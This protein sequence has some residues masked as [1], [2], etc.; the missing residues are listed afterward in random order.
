MKVCLN[1]DVKARWAGKTIHLDYEQNFYSDLFISVLIVTILSGA[2]LCIEN[3]EKRL[4]KALFMKGS[5]EVL[6]SWFLSQVCTLS[7]CS[8]HIS[9]LYIG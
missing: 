4:N 3:K 8:F 6:V 1:T 5:S 2:E 9:C 7:L